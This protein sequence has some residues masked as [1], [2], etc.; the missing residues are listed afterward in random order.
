MIKA[1]RAVV[2]LA[3]AALAGS[4]APGFAQVNATIVINIMRECAKIDDPTARL[5]C[6]DNNIRATGANPRSV[7]GQTVRPSGGGAV[8]APNQPNGFGAD[9]LRTQSPERF[10]Q[11]GDNAPGGPREITTTVAAAREREPGVWLVTLSDGAQWLF[12]ESVGQTYSPP[13][14]G[15]K[16]RI[17]HAALGSYLLV[18]NKQQGVKVT[19]IK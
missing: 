19:R 7:P 10:H 6:Y 5:A 18:V 3:G 8:A 14:K 15:D 2:L 13:R 17:E 12:S 1:P 4:G 11:Y 16:V 9:D